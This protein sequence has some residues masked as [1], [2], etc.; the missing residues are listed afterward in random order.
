MGKGGEEEEKNGIPVFTSMHSKLQIPSISRRAKEV[1]EEKPGSGST[2][3]YITLIVVV[4]FS[5]MHIKERNLRVI[6][7]H[8]HKM[9]KENQAREKISLTY[10]QN[11]IKLH[12]LWRIYTHL[13]LT[14]A[15]I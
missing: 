11:P 5:T 3:A 1:K 6:N 4:T 13:S 12:M 2:A 14:Y 8:H 7:H 10:A 9:R 15:C